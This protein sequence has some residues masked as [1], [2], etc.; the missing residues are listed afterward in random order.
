MR[1]ILGALALLLVVALLAPAFL[2]VPAASACSC[3]MPPIEST[4]MRELFEGDFYGSEWVMITGHASARDASPVP[5]S[6][7]T[8]FTVD[9]V[10]RGSTPERVLLLDASD[11]ASCGMTVDTVGREFVVARLADDGVYEPTY[12]GS[13]S[14]TPALQAELDA[15][16]AGTAPTADNSDLVDIP[17]IPVAFIAGATTILIA[18]V[19]AIRRRDRAPS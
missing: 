6:S 16:S 9:R 17:Y 14:I 10:Y 13:F 12:C 1:K 4:T 19:F 15:A 7:T 18:A 5:H 8:E 11:G 3:A 2:H